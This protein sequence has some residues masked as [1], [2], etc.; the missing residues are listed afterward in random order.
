MDMLIWKRFQIVFILLFEIYFILYGRQHDFYYHL[1]DLLN[2]LAR[3]WID[4]PDDPGSPHDPEYAQF[5]GRQAAGLLVHQRT[6][7]ADLA[8]LGGHGRGRR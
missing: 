1:E 7:V 2:T 3:M 8:G 5:E 4:R 6:Q